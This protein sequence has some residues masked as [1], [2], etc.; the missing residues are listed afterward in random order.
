MGEIADNCRAVLFSD[1]MYRMLEFDSK[2]RLPSAC[3]ISENGITL[4]GLSKSWG[5]PVHSRLAC[6]T[7]FDIFE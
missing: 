4:C 3:E 1:E 2:D 5:C 7:K 6:I